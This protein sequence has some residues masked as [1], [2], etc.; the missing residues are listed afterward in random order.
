MN[1]GHTRHA[2]DNKFYPERFRGMDVDPRAVG[3]ALC[4]RRCFASHLGTTAL[5]GLRDV[6]L[7]VLSHSPPALQQPHRHTSLVGIHARSMALFHSII[8]PQSCTRL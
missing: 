1:A 2:T 4:V 7:P 3:H 6:P 8:T 5:A